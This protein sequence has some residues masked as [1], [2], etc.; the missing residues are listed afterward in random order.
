MS[1]TLVICKESILASHA[2]KRSSI[3]WKGTLLGW[4]LVITW[5]L[6]GWSCSGLCDFAPV[7]SPWSRLS[8]A[9]FSSCCFR[10]FLAQSGGSDGERE[11]DHEPEWWCA[12]A[13]EDSPR[14]SA[15]SLIR[16]LGLRLY[17]CNLFKAR[18]LVPELSFAIKIYY[19]KRQ[20]QGS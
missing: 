11:G 7:N 3:R 18:D 5:G 15:A 1:L 9:A 19:K 13:R 4:L 16:P 20:K 2:N 6:S 12:E 14:S 8:S 10:S 17:G